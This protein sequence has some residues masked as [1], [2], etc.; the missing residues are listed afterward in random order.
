MSC[1]FLSV[2]GYRPAVPVSYEPALL[3]FLKNVQDVSF[4]TIVVAIAP[5]NRNVVTTSILHTRSRCLL[6]P[7]T[8]A[9]RF[10]YE[11]SLWLSM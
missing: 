11:K 3:V 10:L 8:K 6:P 4:V 9:K 5:A 7:D 2:I 1:L